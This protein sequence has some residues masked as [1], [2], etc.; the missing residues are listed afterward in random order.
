MSKRVEI[1]GPVD[2]TRRH[3][4]TLAERIARL[5]AR[6]WL[7]NRRLQPTP[8]AQQTLPPAKSPTAR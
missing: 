5:L 3:R 7:A 1:P 6:R 8:S 4:D 2:I